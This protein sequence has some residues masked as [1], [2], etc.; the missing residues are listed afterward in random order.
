MF[1]QKGLIRALRGGALLGGVM[2]MSRQ[3]PIWKRCDCNVRESSVPFLPD[4][5]LP[6]SFSLQSQNSTYQNISPNVENNFQL[7][8]LF[9]YTNLYIFPRGSGY[10]MLKLKWVP[11]FLASGYTSF[12]KLV[13]SFKVASILKIATSSNQPTCKILY[14][15]Q[16]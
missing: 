7:S 3:S 9:Y 1:A 14:V 2:A 11:F 13:S 16:I 10:T 5:V 6:M 12:T 4:T 8:I 15:Y